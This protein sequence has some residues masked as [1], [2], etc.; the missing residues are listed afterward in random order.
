MNKGRRLATS[1]TLVAGLLSVTL[2]GGATL[3]LEKT[4]HTAHRSAE[5]SLERTA[6][7][8][9]STVNRQLLQ[10]DIALAS[11]PTLITALSRSNGDVT[12]EAA[13]RLLRG[14]NFQA[15]AFRDILLVRPDGTVWASARPRPRSRALP[16]NPGELST[17]PGTGA[18]A[19]N[20]PVRNPLTGEWALFLSRPV[21]LPGA[22]TLLAV[23]EVPL[24]TL[25]TLLAEAGE[26]PGLR[27][28]LERDDGTLLAS[29]P[30][31]E[32]QIGKVQPAAIGRLSRD[33]TAVEVPGTPAG[34]PMIAAAR[35]S[36]YKD[37]T[38]ALTLETA[39]AMTDWKRDRDRLLAVVLLAEILVLAS[40]GALHAAFRRQR[41]LERERAV[42]STRLENAIEAMS[43]GFVMWDAD[44]RLVT[45]NQKYRELYAVSAP[46]IQVGAHFEDVLRQG[47]ALGQYPNIGSD[48]EA[49][50][51]HMIGWHRESQGSMERLLPDGRWVLITERRTASGEIVGTRTD[52]T[53]IK[54]ALSD[55]EA[56]NER[57]RHQNRLFDAALNNMSHGLL[58]ADAGRHV[59]VCN[60]RFMELF[61]LAEADVAPGTHVAE[62][63]RAIVARGI[64]EA[65]TVDDI[66]RR[67]EDLTLAQR[68]G[69]F[70]TSDADGATL[71]ITQRP[72][73][74][75]GFVAIYEDVTEQQHAESRIRFLA[76]HDPLTRLPNRILF[77]SRLE[78]ML[79]ASRTRGQGLAL[80]Y[81]DLDKFK[82]VN[83]TLGHPV[84]DAL[85]EAVGNRLRACLGD[86]IIV[87]RL[88]G[89][90]FA[91]ACLS[92]D[93]PAEAARLGERIIASLSAPYGLDG[94]QVTVGVSV[95]IAMA[96]PDIALDADTLLKNA[97]MALY[98]AKASGRGVSRF[99]EPGI[100]SKLYARL[101]LERDLRAALAAEQFELA[102]QPVFDLVADRVCGFE[103]LIRWP[104]PE[105]GLVSPAEFIP[106]AE[107]TELIGEIG[108]FVLNR[109]CADAARLP[110]DVRIAVNLSPV[111]LRT[112]DIVDAV[113]SA[114]QRSGLDPRRLE[115]EITESALL[116]DNERI[117]T[118]LERLRGLG[119]RLVLDDFGTGYSSLSYLRRFPFD[120][121]KIDQSFVREMTTRSNCVAI[122]GAVV[123]L[124]DELGMTATAEG[125][126]TADQ[127]DL[128]RQVGCLEAQGY[129]LGRPKPILAAFELLRGAGSAKP[130]LPLAAVGS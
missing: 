12:S 93:L 6:R 80:L 66:R 64:W 89:D 101:E 40:A 72:M 54:T 128:V 123:G 108:A 48:V 112:D 47:A 103:A 125:V 29:L 20:G 88:G 56:A 118:L 46:V 124:A 94:R 7:V 87:A 22:D 85:L 42:A 62:V 129:L 3:V 14:L 45:C 17:G 5:V 24:S 110:G 49:W 79:H 74:D 23:A 2:L 100:E 104:H 41:R 50:L 115:L 25:G 35:P 26:A 77:R 63:Y 97:D 18:I 95:G 67:Q 39:T 8:V 1:V 9:E 111:Q 52:I 83:D 61:G 90:E 99:F 117:A 76:H 106:L 32:L 98:E 70:K 43:D 16:I 109:A 55:L 4:W 28:M 120:K 82:D 92:P 21:S 81:L 68:N 60:R 122:V 58:M 113:A 84:G 121:I 126:E 57:A 51:D 30:H 59:I 36:L 27:V 116:E 105:R 96:T 11:L 130:T 13:N 114:L 37:I 31:D 53:P 86:S 69:T 119:T 19:V 34:T 102:Y 44:D 65:G 10:V 71:S 127:L 33:G 38:V 73:D 107:E 15:Y 91:V 78:E 75:G